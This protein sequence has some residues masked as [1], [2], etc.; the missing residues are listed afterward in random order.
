LPGTSRRQRKALAMTQIALPLETLACP[1]PLRPGPDLPPAAPDPGTGFDAEGW[2]IG[3]EHARHGIAP[4]ADHL[5]AGHPVREGWQAG[6]ATFGARALAPSRSSRLWLQLRLQCWLRGRAFDALLV[7]PRLLARIDVARCP[8]TREA[9]RDPV[10][11]PAQQDAVVLALCP[12]AAVSAGHLAVVS[13]RVAEAAAGLDAAQALARARQS[14]ASPAAGAMGVAGAGAALAAACGVHCGPGSSRPDA[15]STPALD[16][17]QWRRLATLL[18]L[19]APA[20]AAGWPEDE[21]LHLLPPPRLRVLNPVPGLQA[22][23]TQLF[24]APAYGRRMGEVAGLLPQPGARRAY[25]QLMS[26]LLARRMSAGSGADPAQLREVLEDAW[27]HPVVRGRWLALA[28][29]LGAAGCARL[30]RQAARRGLAPGARWLDDEVATEGWS[31]AQG[32][33]AAWVQDPAPAPAA[34]PAAGAAA[35]PAPARSTGRARPGDL[36]GPGRYRGKASR[37]ATL[38][39][40]R[41]AE[42]I[43]PTRRTPASPITRSSSESST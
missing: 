10:G 39:T 37:G 26:A 9:L 13:R 23:L 27:S 11:A 17:P 18:A 1:L 14:E 38:G 40:S 31:L 35:P 36:G 21:P 32:G 6:R 30:L 29:A 22:L 12:A 33:R 7:T 43:S 4:P 24:A 34:A 19:V 8:V 42:A 16:A 28:R 41:P 3:W 20:G 2:R 25:F 15:V 5:H